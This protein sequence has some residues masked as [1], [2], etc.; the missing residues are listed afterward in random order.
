MCIHNRVCACSLFE[1]VVDRKVSE[2]LVPSLTSILCAQRSEGKQSTWS[3]TTAA[4]G[5]LVDRGD[6]Q[7]EV[8]FPT[9]S[10]PDTLTHS[11]RSHA[12]PKIAFFYLLAHARTL[13]AFRL[14]L[15]LI[16]SLNPRIFRNNNAGDTAKLAASGRYGDA[17][18]VQVRG[19]LPAADQGPGVHHG[20]G[21]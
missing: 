17:P 18:G 6:Q 3:G 11:L 21:V 14:R 1:A 9:A 4:V 12:L 20:P 8:C 15:S 10:A 16:S 13:T 19:D 5:L 2:S 7:Q